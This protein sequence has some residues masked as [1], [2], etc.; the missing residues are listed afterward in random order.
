MS[1]QGTPCYRASIGHVLPGRWLNVLCT[2][3]SYRAGL[4]FGLCCLFV[5]VV[6]VH[7]TAL[8]VA[9]HEVIQDVEQNPAGRWLL[10]LQHGEIWCFVLAKLTGT[11]LV[12]SVLVRLYQFSKKIALISASTLAVLQFLLLCYLTL[13]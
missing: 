11:A 7:D 8:I 1:R 13:A 2:V 10:D 6:S 4:F 5:A 12:C 9:N 3:A